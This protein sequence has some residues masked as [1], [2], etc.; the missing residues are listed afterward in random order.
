M[1]QHNTFQGLGLQ[2]T[3]K[4]VKSM[5][6]KLRVKSRVNKGTEFY[7]IL[8]KYIPTIN[9]SRW[10]RERRENLSELSQVSN[11]QV[12]KVRSESFEEDLTSR[13][14]EIEE[15]INEDLL[16]DKKMSTYSFTKDA[17]KILPKSR[18]L[19]PNKKQ[20]ALVVDDNG[21]NR[22]AISGLLRRQGIDVIVKMDGLEAVEEMRKQI[23]KFR[24]DKDRKQLVNCIFMDL[25]M[26]NMD[27][28][29]ATNIINTMLNEANITTIPIFALTA[30][31][32][33]QLKTHC[34]AHGFTLFLVKPIKQDALS[35][36]LLKYLTTS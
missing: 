31:D 19:V 18:S 12:K 26:P 17:S 22:I 6:S 28:I 25:N 24:Q 30:Y 5:N 27:G 9:R 34:L 21:V 35:D 32:T 13:M 20:K 23:D 1:I 11:R 29:E 14:C 7:F 16:I 4:L 15:N 10:R 2:I 3:Q 33:N 36:V 8:K